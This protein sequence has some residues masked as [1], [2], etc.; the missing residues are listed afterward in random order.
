MEATS[1]MK[2]LSPSVHC[3]VPPDGMGGV[4]PG[5][6]HNCPFVCVMI[7]LVPVL[8]IWCLLPLGKIKDVKVLT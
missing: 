8:P 2:T 6:R 4:L 7:W 1:Q 5:Q 3:Q